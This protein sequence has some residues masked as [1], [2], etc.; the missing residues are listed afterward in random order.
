MVDLLFDRFGF[1]QTNKAVANSTYAKQLNPNKINRR[2]A[3]QLTLPLK[4]MFS[5]SVRV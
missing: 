1:D 4:L 5:A 2:S 3:T